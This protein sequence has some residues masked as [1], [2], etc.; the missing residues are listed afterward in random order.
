MKVEKLDKHR[1]C[2]INDLGNCIAWGS[3]QSMMRKLKKYQR[4]EAQP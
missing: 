3:K 4:K 2:L 1:W